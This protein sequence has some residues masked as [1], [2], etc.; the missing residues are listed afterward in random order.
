[1]KRWGCWMLVWAAVGIAAV[2]GLLG[3]MEPRAEEAVPGAGEELARKAEAELRKLREERARGNKRGNASEFAGKWRL[4]LPAGFKYDVE[5]TQRDDGLLQLECP[6][7]ALNLLGRFA[8]IG[9]ELRLVA[10]REGQVDEY[11]W[12]YRDGRFELTAEKQNH[13]AHYKGA[14]LTRR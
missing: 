14:T 5:L 7:H 12:T 3:A 9:T 1:M 4:T 11:I 10:P 8:C 13:G 6:G 2:P